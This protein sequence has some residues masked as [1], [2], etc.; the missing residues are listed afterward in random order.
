MS[1]RWLIVV[2]VIFVGAIALVWQSSEP[3]EPMFEGRP[4][5]SW[6]DH[7]VP[8]SAANPPYN[9]PGWLKAHE[10]IRAIGTNGIP[11]LLR[12]IRAKD[13]PRP[14]IKALQKV[15]RY[16]WTYHYHY[17]TPAERRSRICL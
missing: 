2:A 5:S 1:K 13:L 17:K 8:S 14:M 6:M 3:P 12:M 9:S 4:L 10:A 15:D 11:T 7:H 16:R